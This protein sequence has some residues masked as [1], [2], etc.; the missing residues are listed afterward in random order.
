VT[1]IP[2]FNS[3]FYIVAASV[4]PVYFLALI[5]PGGILY[6]YWRA[7]ELLHNRLAAPTGKSIVK[8]ILIA[9]FYMLTLIPP[10]CILAS[11]AFGETG[12]LISLYRQ[13]VFSIAGIPEIFWL[14]GLPGIAALGVM[15]MV[16]YETTAKPS[17]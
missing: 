13:N 5:L 10:I 15:V 16:A 2:T 9:L 4:I 7:S 6:R 12:A 1:T 11:E 8:Q 3:N 14:A 17:D